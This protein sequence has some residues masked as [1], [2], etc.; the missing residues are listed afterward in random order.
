MPQNRFYDFSK[1][2][3]K[4]TGGQPDGGPIN[5]QTYINAL[6]RKG[7]QPGSPYDDP[8]VGQDNSFVPGQKLSRLSL[9]SQASPAMSALVN[10]ALQPLFAQGLPPDVLFNSLLAAF[11]H[12]Y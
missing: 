1:P 9:V 12:Q 4:P 5:S 10:S 2:Y 3:P 8:F 7:I 11:Q 6:A